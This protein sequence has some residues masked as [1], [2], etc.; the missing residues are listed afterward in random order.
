MLLLGSALPFA[1]SYQ[2]QPRLV[3]PRQAEPVIPADR[4]P[5]HTGLPVARL[6]AMVAAMAIMGAI[7]GILHI[8]VTAYAAETRLPGGA[9]LLYAG[10]EVGSAAA[11]LVYAAL[12][13]RFSLPMRYL[14][15]A[16]LLVVGM[17]FLVLGEVLIPLPVAVVLAG[18]AIAPYLI[19]VYALTEQLAPARV[20]TA[21][22][23]LAAGGP[24]GT[25][26]GQVLAGAITQDHGY[27][28]A[29]ALAPGAAALA[30]L[31]AAAVV[32]GDR[33]RHRR[34]SHSLT[35]QECC[36]HQS[37]PGDG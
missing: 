28:A 20:A 9:G 34:R 23:I 4:K 16:A 17:G 27:R 30:L 6:A 29:L 37:D 21:M 1:L 25:A 2:P 31:L 5:S 18:A 12:P 11:G 8:A 13:Q 7:F 10:L 36:K 24:V 15:F 26:A 14:T 3:Q 33:A 22:T 32:T 19:S 35:N